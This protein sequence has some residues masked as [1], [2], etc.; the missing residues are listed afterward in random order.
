MGKIYRIDVSKV[1]SFARRFEIEALFS[2]SW[3]SYPH[4]IAPDSSHRAIDYF[5]IFCPSDIPPKFPELSDPIT[6]TEV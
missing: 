2:V 3:D 5:D 1:D 4:F 6:I